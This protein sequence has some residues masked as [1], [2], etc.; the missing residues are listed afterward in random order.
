MAPAGAF[1]TPQAS[2]GKTMSLRQNAVLTMLSENQ[3]LNKQQQLRAKFTPNES[4]YFDYCGLAGLR[5]L[6]EPEMTEDR[7]LIKTEQLARLL[8]CPRCGGALKRNGTRR[9]VVRDEPRGVRGVWIEVRRQGYRCTREDC[10]KPVL[11]PL[12]GVDGKRRMTT[13]LV[14]Y[15]QVNALLDKFTMVALRTGLSVR[16]VS[17][18][19]QEYVNTLDQTFQ[20]KTPRVLGLDGVHIERADTRQAEETLAEEAEEEKRDRLSR[21]ERGII[22]DIE[23]GQVIDV[24]K[25][26]SKKEMIQAIRKIPDYQ[27]VEVAVIDMSH[28]LRNAV[29]EALPEAVIVIDR[30]HVQR[31]ANDSMDNVR[32]R[33]RKGVDER[34]GESFMCDKD[35]LRKHWNKLTREEQENL[36]SWFRYMPELGMAYEMKEAYFE[37][38]NSPSSAIARKRY[39]DWR[40]RLVGMNSEFENDF[41]PLLSVM[42]NYWG[43]YIFN[44]FDHRYTNAF[45]EQA[46]RQLRDILTASRSCGFKTYRAKIVYGTMVRKQMEQQREMWAKARKKRSLTGRKRRSDARLKKANKIRLLP[47]PPPRQISL[48]CDAVMQRSL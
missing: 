8:L 24:R 38:W 40:D 15:T 46:N 27:Q 6:Q 25:N 11:Q 18:I 16:T 5:T 42:G 3:G 37:I 44:Y 1:E 17:E 28:P 12:Y 21:L 9:Q 32:K 48:L 14:R 22:T 20:F 39:Q 43:K 10:Q 33:L 31:Y 30:F 4:N 23:A 13:R 47:T 19:F 35:L 7:I 41:Q 2:K 34:P 29:E 26:C 45:T 36:K